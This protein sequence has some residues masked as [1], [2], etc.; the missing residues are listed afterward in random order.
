MFLGNIKS[1]IFKKIHYNKEFEKKILDVTNAKISLIQDSSNH[2]H[3]LDS[4]EI[5]TRLNIEYTTFERDLSILDLSILDFFYES[6]TI[7]I[8]FENQEISFGIVRPIKID[9]SYNQTTMEFIVDDYQQN[10]KI[11]ENIIQKNRV[12]T[13]YDFLEI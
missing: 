12:I 4:L 13:D 10:N 1:F 7:Q 11:I 8:N 2:Y 5:N 9:V 6:N 3:N